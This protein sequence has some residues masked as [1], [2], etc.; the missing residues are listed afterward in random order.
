MIPNESK[1]YTVHTVSTIYKINRFAKVYI[2]GSIFNVISL[3]FIQLLSR[4]DRLEKGQ[5]EKSGCI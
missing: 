1:M 5:L 3:Y 4:E 2:F